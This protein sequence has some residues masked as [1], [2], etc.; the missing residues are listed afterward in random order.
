M[1]TLTKQIELSEIINRQESHLSFLDEHTPGKE[2]SEPEEPDLFDIQNRCIG[3][4][5]QHVRLFIRS[6]L[7]YINRTNLCK[8]IKMDYK[9]LHDFIYYEGGITDNQLFELCK[10]LEKFGFKSITGEVPKDPKNLSIEFI[11]YTVC[12]YFSMPIEYIDIATRKREVVQARQIAMYFAKFKTKESL[13]VIGLLTGGKDHATA[14]Y[15]V[16]QVLNL[17]DTDKRYKAQIDEI[18]KLLKQ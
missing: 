3:I 14:I 11:K 17:I 12:Q 16:R 4:D 10:V 8:D 6:V 18:E 15:A 5:K 9:Y 1:E 2:L 7:R 13:R